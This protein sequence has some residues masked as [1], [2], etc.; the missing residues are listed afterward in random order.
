MR[1]RVRRRVGWF[2]EKFVQNRGETNRIKFRAR[3]LVLDEEDVD[4][5]VEREGRQR[6]EPM[7]EPELEKEETCGQESRC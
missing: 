3:V 7:T 2:G 4:G 6:E 5:H 1:G